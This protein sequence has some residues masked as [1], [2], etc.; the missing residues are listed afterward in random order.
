MRL[1]IVYDPGRLRRWHVW[2]AHALA[3]SHQVRFARVVSPQPLPAAPDLLQRFERIV[4]G[5]G[6]ESASDRCC[7]DDFSGHLLNDDDLKDVDIAIDLSGNGLQAPKGLRVI[8]PLYNGVADELGAIDAILG[9]D[10]VDLGLSDTSLPCALYLGRSAIE[11][12][13]ILSKSLDTVF[14]RMAALILRAVDHKLEEGTGGVRAQTKSGNTSVATAGFL[15]TSVTRKV[16]ALLNRLCTGGDQWSVAWRRSNGSQMC[17]PSHD[18]NF[19]LS[20]LPN[21]PGSYFADPFLLSHRGRHY[22]FVEEFLFAANKGVISVMT[23][24]ADGSVTPSRVVLERPYHLSYPFV[25]E[26]GGRI[27][28]IPESADS[29]RVELYAA[30]QFPY[31]WSLEAVLLDGIAAYDATL[32]KQAGRY[33]MMMTTTQWQSSSWDTLEIFHAPA[34]GGPWTEIDANPALIDPGS[35]RPAGRMYH[36]A[37]ELWRPAQDSAT[38]YGAHCL[39]CRVDRLDSS[40]FRQSPIWRLEPAVQSGLRGVHTLNQ[41]DG[42]EVVDIFGAQSLEPAQLSMRRVDASH[43]VSHKAISGSR[44]PAKRL[45]RPLTPNG[46][47]R[48]LTSHSAEPGR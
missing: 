39:L 5:R 15:A 19:A 18:R 21:N 27:F 8:A 43:Q 46:R 23:I 6:A 7:T 38:I 47:R 13:N 29:R 34:L 30:D 10:P 9:H 3:E 1:L 44:R 22:L 25:F 24:E 36:R 26:H 32:C 42:I 33:W 12:P 2:L 14:C 48:G 28:M 35:A 16:L 45:Y 37:G 41:A 31:S 17:E 4:I 40:Q 11:H 20:R